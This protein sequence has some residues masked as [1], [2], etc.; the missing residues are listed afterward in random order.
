M[1][2]G[3]T[4]KARSGKDTAADFTG[5]DKYSFA[6][7]IKDACKAIFD[8]DDEHVNGPLKEVVDPKYGVSPRQA[9]QTL[10]TD[11]ARDTINKDIWLIRART[12]LE[13]G[14][15]V[16]A[17]VRFDNEAELIRE[18]GGIVIEVVGKHSSENVREHDSEMGVSLGLIDHTIL[19]D[20]TL[21]DLESQINTIM[22]NLKATRYL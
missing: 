13:H 6:T 5:L 2:V 11:W 15:V 19:N 8:W 9:L 1:L 20:G 22:F 21:E 16:V 7:P 10:G 17:D 12:V 14:N 3:F 18:L 4:G